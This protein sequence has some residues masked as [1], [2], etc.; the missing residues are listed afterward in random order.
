MADERS[1]NQI[2]SAAANHAR[3]NPTNHQELEHKA[4]QQHSATK[5]QNVLRRKK[6]GKKD[7]PAITE[8]ARWDRPTCSA[9]GKEGARA[10]RTGPSP[11]KASRRRKRRR[12]WRWNLHPSPSGSECRR[13]RRFEAARGRILKSSSPPLLSQVLLGLSASCSRCSLCTTV[14]FVG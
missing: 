4:L 1:A 5:I 13:R 11:R 3:I 10:V 9:H 6:K 14:H 8:A 7:S 12:L 2:C